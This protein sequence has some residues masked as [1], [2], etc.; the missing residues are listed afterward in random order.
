M[1]NRQF[2]DKNVFTSAD[3][4]MT[5]LEENQCAYPDS[6]THMQFYRLTLQ[7]ARSFKNNNTRRFTSTA[8][9]NPSQFIAFQD[10]CL[11]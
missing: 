3:V 5:S 6:T 4:G 11:R 9:W 7:R 2:T 1:R 10:Y 8:E